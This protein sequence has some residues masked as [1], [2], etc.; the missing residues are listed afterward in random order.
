M[1]TNNPPFLPVSFPS[2][3]PTA[4]QWESGPGPFVPYNGSSQT[5]R[6]N[7]AKPMPPW[8]LG[9]GPADPGLSAA[10]SNYTGSGYGPVGAGTIGV[11]EIATVT[12][13]GP[14]AQVRMYLQGGQLYIL[15]NVSGTAYVVQ[16]AAQI[17]QPAIYSPTK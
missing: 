3:P 9:P 11:G 7:V 8:E 13:A 17:P 1:A 2:G 4:P 14:P 12:P 15:D 10:K 16:A 6:I 5:S